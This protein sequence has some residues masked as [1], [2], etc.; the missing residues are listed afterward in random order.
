MKSIILKTAVTLAVMTGLS[1]CN[2]SSDD[3]PNS[4][5]QFQGTSFVT[6]TDVAISDRLTASDP[7]G[8]QISFN[9]LSEAVSGSVVL[10]RNGDFV[11]TPP[12]EFTGTDSFR[13]QITD[14]K[15][16]V[17][18][19]VSIDI[20]VAVVSFLNYSRSAFAQEADAAPLPVNGREFTMDA[21][22]EAD[23]A[24]LLQGL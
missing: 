17:E 21:M 18:S 5:P 24:D 22:S 23:Y 7:D 13:V 15:N 6:E 2:S 10:Q 8:D 14:G 20:Q 16:F 19:M 11:Y 4:P 1:A 12:A 3:E 9:L